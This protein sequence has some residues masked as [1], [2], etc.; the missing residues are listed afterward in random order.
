MTQR[1]TSILTYILFTVTLLWGGF[2][3]IAYLGVPVHELVYQTQTQVN[4]IGQTCG[5][6]A[7]VSTYLCSGFESLMPFLKAIF[8]MGSPFLAYTILSM[9]A[10]GAVLL[11]AGYKTG[12][13][14]ATIP[15]R[16]VTLIGLFCAS[17][18][19]IGTTFSLGT[20]YNLNT[21]QS[22]MMQDASGQLAPP[23]FRRFIEPTAKVYNA[24]APETLAEL[25]NNYQ[26]LLD[27]GCLNDTGLV[28]RGDAKV[29]DLSFFCMQESLFAR[30][31]AQVV[32][33]LF[34]LF[35]LIVL[36]SFLIVTVLRINIVRLTH[37][38]V[39]SF[40]IG[41]L[42]WVMI[43]WTLSLFGWL[44]SGPVWVL[45]LCIPIAL[46][47]YSWWWLQRFWDAK[48]DVEFSLRNVALFLGW[49]LLT[50]LAL[51]FLNVVRP[52][53]IG[54]DDLGSYLNRPRLL[55]SYGSFIP[56]MSQFQW[57]YLTSLGFVLFGFDST[58]GSTF[59]MQINWMAGLLSVLSVYIFARTY[60]GRGKGI[61]S[62]MLY[63]FLPMTGHFSFADMKIDN[64]SFF[65]TVLAIFAAMTYL[66]PVADGETE[67]PARTNWKLLLLAGLLAG[68]SFSIKATGVLGI[69]LICSCITAE[70]LGSL[71]FV[72]VVF[73]GFF[74]LAKFGP[75]NVK[76]IL[77]RA[78][79]PF[80]VSQTHLQLL[81]ILV[82][83]AFFI[84][85]I[86]R[87][88]AALREL[89]IAA[90]LF[91]GGMAIVI[92]PYGVHNMML[93]GTVSIPAMMGA[94]DFVSPQV[95]YLQADEVAAQHLP[96]TVPMR[97]LPPELKLNPS[98]PAC[99]S[100]ARTEELDRYWGF[101]KGISHYLALPWRQVMNIDAFGYYVTLMP[102]LLLFILLLLYPSLWDD[103]YERY[104]IATAS[105]LGVLLLHAIL[106]LFEVG[107]YLAAINWL[108][109]FPGGSL[110]LGA[111]L[112]IFLAL[113]FTALLWRREYRWLGLLF[114]G[115]WVFLMQWA[116]VANGVAWY[117]LGMFFGFA[118]ALEAL[119]SFAPDASTRWLMTFFIAM[120]ILVCLLNRLWQF[121][122]QKNLF[123]Y[124]LGKVSATALRESTIPDYDNI[125]QSVE[126][127]R[128]LMPETPY[129]YRIGTFISY[130]IPKNREVFP[131]ADHQM[132]FFNCI[133]QE[134]NHALTLKRLKALGFN[135]I[136]FD[137][138][139]QTIEKD[140]NGSLHQKVQ[141]FTNFVNDSSIGLRIAVNDPGN[142][143]AYILLP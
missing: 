16:P 44:H 126:A 59:A 133:N 113:P 100:S 39:F 117:G 107:W 3:F 26:E 23:P 49:L 76:D 94:P 31:G 12:F 62:A 99:M 58:I 87:Q 32:L 21:P 41:A 43:L 71:G 143:I 64:A 140:P 128:E 88:R 82:S 127:R 25:Q 10:F 18:W 86:I 22:E 119:V 84:A 120:S 61:L 63:Y 11:W 134:R 68:F 106:S 129:T 136:I 15:F 48:W 139:T 121:D 38:F 81:L 109:V 78:A 132:G 24:A 1:T 138:N 7:S 52:F 125:R 98:D 56:S 131:L 111:C 112:I 54:W 79:L 13:F 51:N 40:G 105:V 96:A 17:V 4:A 8:L 42:A 130:F 53:P 123:E 57:E 115:T 34:F 75:L 60:F 37:L 95:S 74:A 50:Y 104:Q 110:L 142:G 2:T 137:T 65:V 85:A 46:F 5:T 122:S 45:F 97:S 9:L 90:G 89:S 73:A 20:V 72:G 19:L 92:L 102:A 55:A 6:D 33:L 66:F 124:P 28:T 36:G 30:A 83:G 69:F 114:A 101:G 135:G 103:R 35:N 29:Y 93:A 67:E 77:G 47:K 141:A 108:A 80:T 27:R 70:F 91:L 14:H 118:I 116:F